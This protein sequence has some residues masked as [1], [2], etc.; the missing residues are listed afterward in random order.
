MDENNNNSSL[1]VVQQQQQQ[2]QIARKPPTTVAERLNLSFNSG[3]S[4]NNVSFIN[5]NE[6]LAAAATAA[7][8][9]QANI[10]SSSSTSSSKTSA[11]SIALGRGR[12]LKLLEEKRGLKQGSPPTTSSPTSP[13]LAS[14]QSLM[15]VNMP[16]VS[17]ASASASASTM[18]AAAVARATQHHL[19]QQQQQQQQQPTLNALAAS[20]P[21]T[22]A[23]SAV[24][25]RGAA[26]TSASSFIT[27][28]VSQKRKSP[29]QNVSG[30]WEDDDAMSDQEMMDASAESEREKMYKTTRGLN[31]SAMCSPPSVGVAA[32]VGLAGAANG[33]PPRGR[34]FGHRASGSYSSSSSFTSISTI[35][36]SLNHSRSMSNANA[37]ATAN[38]F[39][40]H[41]R[42][43]ASQGHI[44]SLRA[45]F[46]RT[47]D[48]NFRFPIGVHACKQSDLVL[49]CDSFNNA[50]KVFEA[51]SGRI[52]HEIS[53]TH[54]NYKRQ[55]TL[56]RPSAVIADH[57]AIY[58]KDDKEI[59][60][61]D[62]TAAFHYVRRFGFKT[63]KRPYGLAFDSSGAHVIVVDADL[64]SPTLYMFEAA[65]GRLVSAK[66]YQPVKAASASYEA[67]AALNAALTPSMPTND[68]GKDHKLLSERVA[69]FDKT[70]IRFMCCR[71][72][73]LYASDL[74]RSIVYKTNLDGEIQM[75]FGH[76]G[77]YA[78]QFIEPS[79]IYV[80]EDGS[81][82][83]VGDSKNN[84]VQVINY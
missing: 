3:T 32:G 75:A 17:S 55:F 6:R 16:S 72:E 15:S 14:L 1:P 56:V 78:G 21:A 18:A 12:L 2:Q 77:R 73:S 46:E 64:S 62:K 9:A 26:A 50:V 8:A 60:V 38:V 45:Q 24:E 48:F 7:A 13:S 27:T 25:E 43:H 31:G 54:P 63:L 84:R 74:G 30:V 39:S 4:S 11:P 82:I 5:P 81:A 61:F 66:P 71:G 33:A 42:N 83:V 68:D 58:V 29:L 51:S 53:G 20:V 44:P 57:S 80:S 41:F 35:S 59:L 65:S 23:P 76:Y 28:S 22:P 67:L 36:T 70:K 79:G 37:T 40:I 47:Y 69:S 34:G 10:S 19:Q 52:L 49:V